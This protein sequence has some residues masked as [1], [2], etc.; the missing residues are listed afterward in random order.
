VYYSKQNSING[1]Y[2]NNYK[3]PYQDNLKTVYLTLIL[4]ILTIIFL[5]GVLFVG[6]LFMTEKMKQKRDSSAQKIEREMGVKIF[7]EPIVETKFNTQ[8]V[9]NM[10]HISTE[11]LTQDDIALVVEM[12]MNKMKKARV[13]PKSILDDDDYTKELLSQGVD[14]LSDSMQSVEEKREVRL[15]KPL[16]KELNHYNKVVVGKPKEK[17]HT[18]DRLSQLSSELSSLIDGDL[19]NKKNSTY[20]KEITKEVSVRSNE[21]RVIVVKKGDTLSLIAKRAY[22]DQAAYKKIFKANPEVINNPNQIFVGQKLR[23][24]L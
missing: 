1:D 13:N 12:V 14:G 8:T 17:Q 23:I 15:N 20:T 5:L 18:N 2:Y 11:N 6:Y 10:T 24:P 21:M 7:E 19:L 4:K 16:L 22:G 9:A 3:N